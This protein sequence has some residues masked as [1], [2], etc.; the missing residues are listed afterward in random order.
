V[1]PTPRLAQGA[2]RRGGAAAVQAVR[3]LGGPGA[4]LGERGKLG[5]EGLLLAAEL[6][7][8]FLDTGAELLAHAGVGDAAGFFQFGDQPV[9]A[10]LEV[11]DLPVQ[12]GAPVRRCGR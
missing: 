7:A 1:A 9:P 2:R 4:G 6:G 5:L 3:L 11:R 12:L 10:A 8:T